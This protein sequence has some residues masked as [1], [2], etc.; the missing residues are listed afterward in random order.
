M[1]LAYHFNALSL[2]T[3]TYLSLERLTALRWHLRYYELITTKE[4]SIIV[5]QPWVF[6]GAMSIIVWFVIGS[7]SIL[8]ALSVAGAFGCILVICYC[9]ITIWKIVRR[10]Q[11]R[12]Q[13]HQPTALSSQERNFPGMLKN[14]ARTYTSLIIL[15]LFAL[16]YFPYLCVEVVKLSRIDSPNRVS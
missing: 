14:K 5:I 2:G 8:A 11:K 6:H 7:D 16:C 13:T 1:F 12:I 10:H 15:E 3:L 4:V 9:Y